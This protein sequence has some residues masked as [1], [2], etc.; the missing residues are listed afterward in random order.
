MH[1]ESVTVSY[2][3]RVCQRI[4]VR[5]PDTDSFKNGDC[6]PDGLAVFFANGHSERHWDTHVNRIKDF[7]ANGVCVADAD[8][9]RYADSKYVVVENTERISD[10]EP[11]L[12]AELSAVKLSDYNCNGERSVD[13]E[14]DPQPLANSKFELNWHPK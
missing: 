5:I 13:F 3:K 2:A 9:E 12:D 10:A 7:F 14:L 1:S 4:T 6:N 11:D 8:A